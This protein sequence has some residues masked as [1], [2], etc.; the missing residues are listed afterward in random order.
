MIN[1]YLTLWKRLT[2]TKTVK[3][4]MHMLDNKAS[5]KFKVSIKN[6][7]KIQLVPPDT[8]QQNLAEQAIQTFKNHFKA[9]I[10][11]LDE[12]FPIKLWDKLLPQTILTLNLLCQSNAVPTMSAHQYVH[13]QFD[14]NAMP[15]APLGC[16]VQMHEAPNKRGTWAENAIDSWYIQ[17]SPEHYRCHIIYTKRTNSIR[18]LDMVW[19]KHKYITQPTLTPADI[20]VKALNALTQMLKRKTN[21]EG[22]EEPESL[23]CLEE[24]LTNMPEPRVEH[25]RETTQDTAKPR[26]EHPRETTQD[27]A[28]PR[29]KTTTVTFSTGTKPPNRSV[30]S[31][32]PPHTV[33]PREQKGKEKSISKAT[34]DKSMP[35]SKSR[36]TKIQQA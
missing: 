19:F 16:A 30:I 20:I 35:P 12:T 33:Q 36:L 4:K 14:Y 6:N 21:L 24:I 32:T 1:A 8:H 15:L 29:V 9:I 23:K 31:P 5:D 7:C 13:G 2:G 3:P 17:T 28:E 22:L 18:I 27:T 26:V 10:Q 34:I 25:P 11:G